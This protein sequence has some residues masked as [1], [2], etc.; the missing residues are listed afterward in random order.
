MVEWVAVLA[1]KPM[2]WV[3]SLE[4]QAVEE[5]TPESRPLA[6]AHI[7]GNTVLPTQEEMSF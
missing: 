4:T 5:Q 7:H 6:Y 2:I 1:A 3:W